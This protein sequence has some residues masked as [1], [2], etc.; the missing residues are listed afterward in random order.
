MELIQFLEQNSKDFKTVYYPGADNDYSPL[1]LFAYHTDIQQVYFSDYGSNIKQSGLHTLANLEFL[2]DDVP[3]HLYQ[4]REFRH[5][6]PR[7]FG[8]SFWGEF[9]HP[10]P[11][12]H[13]FGKPENAWGIKIGMICN[14]EPF[15]FIYLGTEG[16][17]TVSV[18]LE[19]KIIPDVL[20][21]QEHETGGNWSVFGGT[22]SPLLLTMK[23]H[24]PKY[25]LAHP[26]SNT[27]M[28]PGYEQITDTW[29]P[30]K[31]D[32]RPLHNNPRALF[33]RVN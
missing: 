28:W 23:H 27:I 24:L 12:S 17:G 18:L 4:L 1:N 16:V 32:F 10:S 25:I 30:E 7:D 2:E 13:E 9:W 11:N 20:V 33:R 29:L 3:F 8:K 15:D 31:G 19:N 26:Q 6:S 22:D 5:L 14:N 21:L